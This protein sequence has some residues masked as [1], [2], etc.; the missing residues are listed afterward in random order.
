MLNAAKYHNT[1][2]HKLY[3]QN[4][5]K[6]LVYSPDI[7]RY[8]VTEEAGCLSNLVTFGLAMDILV[9]L[10]LTNV[11]PKYEP[12]LEQTLQGTENVRL[13]ISMT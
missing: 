12:W 1:Q 8:Q 2:H 4:G 7:L 11:N 13:G 6:C 9:R 5:I 3:C 10:R